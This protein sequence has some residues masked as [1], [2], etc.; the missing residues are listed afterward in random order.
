MQEFG[1]EITTLK[2]RDQWKKE[3]FALISRIQA[4]LPTEKKTFI[5]IGLA[6]NE[7]F[8]GPKPR[9]QTSG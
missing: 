5:S 2:M 6:K 3:K 7:N 9:R 1:I 4:P 8:D